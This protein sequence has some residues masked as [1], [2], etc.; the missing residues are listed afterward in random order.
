MI[1]NALLRCG[2]F[3]VVLVALAVPLG[4]YMARVYDGEAKIASRIFGAGRMILPDF[5]LKSRVT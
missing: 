1:Q 5:S 3:F 4:S 2:V